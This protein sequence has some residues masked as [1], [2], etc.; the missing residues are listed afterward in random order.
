MTD[1]MIGYGAK[2]EIWDAS[3]SPP[4]FV[5]IDEVIEINPGE[6]TGDVIDATHFQSPNRRR[7]K[8]AGLID[9]GEGS[10]VINWIPGDLTDV[11]LRE[12]NTSKAVEEHRI[13]FPNGV[14][15]TF[16]AFINGISKS[17]PL[18]DR[19]TATVNVVVAGAEVWD[20]ASA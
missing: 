6:E 19:L 18:D 7:E 9:G 5:E 17:I 2:Y 3:S 15:V 4:A 16:P 1:A 10:L 11:L 13:T 20:Q 8:I 14:T 12:L